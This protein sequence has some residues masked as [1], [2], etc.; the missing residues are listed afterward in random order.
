MSTQHSH[1]NTAAQHTVVRLGTTTTTSGTLSLGVNTHPTLPLYTVCIELWVC[2]V[3]GVGGRAAFANGV[4]GCDS[5]SPNDPIESE[6]NLLLLSGITALIVLSI[7][8]AVSI[9]SG[10]PLH[11]ITF[12]R[13]KPL[14]SNPVSINSAPVFKL[15]EPDPVGSN[16]HPQ[17]RNP[18]YCSRRR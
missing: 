5:K 7:T 18:P 10:T 8:M 15:F 11:F 3:G 9:C 12:W 2:S 14:V 6:K 13:L 16:E 1:S 17:A 4:D